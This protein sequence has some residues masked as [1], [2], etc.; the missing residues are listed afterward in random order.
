MSG[1]NPR[2]SVTRAVEWVDTDASGHQH[3]SAIM[4]WVEAAEAELFLRTLKLPDYFPTVP[5]IHQEIHFKA[6]LWFGQQ[7]TATVGVAKL[8]RTSMT[9]AFEIHG[10]SNDGQPGALAAFGTVT[11]A[12]VP[13]GS[14]K[15]QPW[16]SAV[17]E[18]VA[19]REGAVAPGERTAM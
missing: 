8:G 3:N 18:A 15:A 7:I 9:Y 14:S 13:L 1:T 2:A 5:R 16:P 11:V 6:K 10:H 12:H 17:V 4:R 19:S